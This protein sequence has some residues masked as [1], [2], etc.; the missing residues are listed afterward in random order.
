MMRIVVMLLLLVVAVLLEAAAPAPACLGQAKPPLV[1]CLVI[2]YALRHSLSALLSAA[3]LGGLA[4]DSLA[5]IPLGYSSSY[6]VLLGLLIHAQ[7]QLLF[8]SRWLTQAL[9]GGLSG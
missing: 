9:L 2:C 6:L 1:A 7:R 8:S 5:A 4:S 3:L